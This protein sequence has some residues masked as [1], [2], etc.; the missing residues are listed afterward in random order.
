MVPEVERRIKAKL[1]AYRKWV[2]GRKPTGK[3]R[4]VQYWDDEASP[5]GLDVPLGEVEQQI[6][7]LV[8][9]GFQVDWAAHRRR[10][11]LRV[12][13][14]SNSGTGRWCSP[15]PPVANRVTR[16]ASDQPN[17][18]HGQPSRITTKILDRAESP[19]GRLRWWD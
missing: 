13:D 6:E 11:Y 19:S 12:W 10:V 18:S 5:A 7:G 1:A 17:R 3:A 4:L 15:R 16:R 8:A 14:R 2:T 9:E